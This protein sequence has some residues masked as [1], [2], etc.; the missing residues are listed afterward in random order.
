MIDGQRWQSWKSLHLSRSME[1]MAGSFQVNLA[2][3]H[4]KNFM[5]SAVRIGLPVH[6]EI[7]GQI[8]LDGYIDAINHAYDANAAD[9]TITG[10][11]K[12]GDLVDC[13]ATCDGP[14]EFHHQK[15]D[16]VIA[17]VIAPFNIDLHVNTDVGA[18]FERVAIQPGETAHSLIDRLCRFRAVLPLSNG[19]GGLVLVK[20]SAARSRGRLVYGKNI[21]AGQV[22]MDGSGRHS[23][24]I[25][26]GYN[27]DGDI[28][29]GRV[30]DERITRYR[31]SVI[32]A[33]SQAF[34]M[35]LETRAIW[36]RNMARARGTRAVYEVVGW[37]QD[38][39]TKTLWQPNTLVWVK[40]LARAI[41]REMLITAL[42]FIR[43]GRGTITRLELVLPES[44]DLIP[45]IASQSK[46]PH[47]QMPVW[48]NT[49]N[50]DLMDLS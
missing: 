31:P 3:K 2:Q 47:G 30:S 14:F 21:L 42:T 20:P 9:I 10:R 33:E 18:P 7:E 50:Y 1:Q 32:M 38:I 12:S 15:L 6:I 22:T 13:A 46:T 17:H 5:A 43:D 29:E 4:E 44:Y 34:D 49:I 23:L 45:E 40:D 24:T 16:Q 8:V 25:L 28:S 36:Q 26:Q 48:D 37:Y 39:D 11:D 19:I 27:E 35:S 41:N